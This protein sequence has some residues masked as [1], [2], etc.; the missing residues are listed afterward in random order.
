MFVFLTEIE[1]NDNKQELH[2]R[3]TRHFGANATDSRGLAGGSAL[4]IQVTLGNII[5]S[6]LHTRQVP[7]NDV[8]HARLAAARRCHCS[9][10]GCEIR[11]NLPT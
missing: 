10:H 2:G 9:L 1:I 4:E 11:G 6:S 8:H 7:L 3:S 5:L